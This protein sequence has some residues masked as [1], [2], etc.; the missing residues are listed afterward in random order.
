MRR[1]NM[2]K[3]IR[4]GI[5]SYRR[6][7]GTH[8]FAEGG[9]FKSLIRAA[10]SLSMQAFVFCPLD[11]DW[12][13]RRV[14]GYTYQPDR[15]AWV[16]SYFPLPHVVYDRIFPPRG[17][18]ANVLYVAAR[19]L[20][21]QR[22]ITSFGR[23]LNGKMEV[24]RAVGRQP[25]WAAHVPET[26]R[27]RGTARLSYMLKK[28]R[29]VFIKP[30]HGTQGKGVLRVTVTRE[31][32]SCRGRDSGNRPYRTTV[33]SPAGIIALA[34]GASKRRKLL[35]QQGLYLNN[36]RGSTFDIRCIV[37][38]D[39]NGEWQLT[40][41]AARI[42]RSGSVTSNLHGGGR[43][44]RTEAVITEIFR[45]RAEEILENIRRVA[46][47]IAG[48]MD[49]GLGDFGEIGLDLGVDRDGKVWLIEANSKPGRTVFLRIRARDLRRL[50]ILRPMQYCKYLAEKGRRSK[51]NAADG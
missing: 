36:F 37:Q 48:A 21:R 38:K 45:E 11:V 13:R 18:M 42:G 2:T 24:Y 10:R 20:V 25:E 19:R 32:F 29:Y 16:A 44:L 4:V 50:S 51:E 7:H 40:G 1:S 23:I 39:E 15:G 17:H 28:Y 41:S 30:E 22:G 49:K 46:I 3:T 34:S 33:S 6:R 8:P 43:A 14:F 26:W 9:Y 12:E 47:G 31:G 27:I 5:M 35:V